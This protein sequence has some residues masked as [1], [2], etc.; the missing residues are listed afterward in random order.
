[1]CEWGIGLDCAGYTQQAFLAA[2]GVSREQAG[3]NPDLRNEGL[4]NLAENGGFSQVKPEKARAGDILALGPP[5]TEN[6]GHRVIVYERHDITQ[7]EVNVLRGT[8]ADLARLRSGRVSV[9]EVDSS[10]GSGG[11]PQ[12]G[13]VLRQKWIYDAASRRWGQIAGSQVAFTITGLP[14]DGLHP[15]LGVYH[16]RGPQRAAAQEGQ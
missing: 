16:F 12:S 13:G 15:L 2:H 3:F 6:A 11:D 8:S 1:M 9:F 14:Y 7:A 5:P 10:W 4:F